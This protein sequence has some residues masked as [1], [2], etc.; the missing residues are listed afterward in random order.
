MQYLHAAEKLRDSWSRDVKTKEQ[1]N[2]L[3]AKKTRERIKVG[4]QDKDRIKE[5]NSL[6]KKEDSILRTVKGRVV[7]IAKCTED[8]TLRAL[9]VMKRINII[10]AMSGNT[11]TQCSTGTKTKC[12]RKD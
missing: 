3:S 5:Q 8:E 12:N 1:S 9:S 11:G 2:V 10:N 7:R 4:K 6:M